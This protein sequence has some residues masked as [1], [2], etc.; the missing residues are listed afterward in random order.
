[1]G[2]F[3]KLKSIF[4]DEVVVE[5][6]ETEELDKVSKIVKKE[7]TPVNEAPK[8][9]ELKFK[10]VEMDPVDEEVREVKKEEPLNERDLFR[11]ERTF[12]FVDF[13]DDDEEEKLPPRRNVL[14]ETNTNNTRINRSTEPARDETPRVFKPTPVISPIWGVLDKDYKKDEIKEK[15]VTSDATFSSSVTDYDN[16]RRKAYGTLEDELEDTLNSVNKVTTDDIN[17]KLYNKEEDVTLSDSRTAKIE[18]IIDKID[19]ATDELDKN[20][21]LE[22]AENSFKLNEFDDDE[23]EKDSTEKTITDSTLEHDLFNLIDSM[24]D[25]E[26]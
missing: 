7:T 25:K 11:S 12:N 19:E 4:Y 1:M 10:S 5:D 26:E 23:N 2:V 16:V 17:T 15:T 6:G 18:D 3:N 14:E 9:E 8:V 20:M 21:S 13:T 22:E 24:Y